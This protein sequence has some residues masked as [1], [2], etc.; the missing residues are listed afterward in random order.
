MC[1]AN[2]WAGFCKTGTSAKK[3][4]YKK[5]LKLKKANFH[6]RYRIEINDAYIKIN[7]RSIPFENFTWTC[8]IK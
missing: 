7:Q 8:R 4:T 2:E 1:K 5:N 6:M 3:Q